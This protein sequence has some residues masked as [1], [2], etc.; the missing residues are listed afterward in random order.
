MSEFDQVE[1]QP[2]GKCNDCG[3]VLSDKDASSAHMSETYAVAKASG[4]SSSHSIRVLN[5]DRDGRI[6]CSVAN[7]V[8]DTIIGALE[9]LWRLVDDGDVTE[10]EVSAALSFHSDFQDAWNQEVAE[11][12]GEET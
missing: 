6:K 5:D 7:V 10:E 2:Y 8:D 11:R 3:V 12:A 4:G 9:E 1:G